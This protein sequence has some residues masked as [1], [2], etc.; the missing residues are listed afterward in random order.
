MILFLDPVRIGQFAKKNHSESFGRV[1]GS[2]ESNHGMHGSQ[3]SQSDSAPPRSH[4]QTIVQ[5]GYQSTQHYNF[6]QTQ[7]DG[8]GVVDYRMFNISAR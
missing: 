2:G 4:S 1:S 8:G 7:R 3:L 6:N 5:V